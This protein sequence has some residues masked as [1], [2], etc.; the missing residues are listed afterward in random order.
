M[1]HIS[2]E[3]G[4]VR[5]EMCQVLCPFRMLDLG[6]PV[7]NGALVG[8]LRA[9]LPVYCLDRRTC[10][11]RAPSPRV[12]VFLFAVQIRRHSGTQTANYLKVC[13]FVK[14]YRVP[15]R[16]SPPMTF[17]PKEGHGGDLIGP[18]CP[19][20]PGAQMRDAPPEHALFL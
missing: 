16:L 4:L 9:P 13:Y 3:F 14:F 7:S 1:C 5:R 6:I 15:T 19:P 20:I 18:V 8:G 11:K 12:L 17:L 2:N 10:V